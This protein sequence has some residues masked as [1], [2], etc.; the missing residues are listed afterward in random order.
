MLVQMLPQSCNV[1]L[2]LKEECREVTRWHQVS[3][4]ED[5]CISWRLQW[6]APSIC[7]HIPAGRLHL[8]TSPWDAPNGD[9]ENCRN[10]PLLSLLIHML[11]ST[12]NHRPQWPTLK[13]SKSVKDMFLKILSLFESCINSLM[14]ISHLHYLAWNQLPSS[15][16]SAT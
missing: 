15:F 8:S 14:C 13:H 16:P 1:W 6:A 2:L 5:A 3:T 12:S 4:W 7:T 10:L 11:L 9:L